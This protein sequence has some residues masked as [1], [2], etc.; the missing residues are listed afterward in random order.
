MTQGKPRIT[1]DLTAMDYVRGALFNALHSG[2]T[3]DDVCR[4]SANAHS[5]EAFDR[6]VNMLASVMPRASQSI[7]HG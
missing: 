3:L 6:A 4:M 2:L 7:T 1:L 5:P